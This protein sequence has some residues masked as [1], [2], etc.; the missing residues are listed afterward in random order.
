MINIIVAIVTLIAA[1]FLILWI[2]RP[3]FR[4][5]VER[6]KYFMLKSE[7]PIPAIAAHT[8]LTDRQ[9]CQI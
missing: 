8:G 5:W 9:T 6:P 7:E 3:S 1:G 4:N 2:L